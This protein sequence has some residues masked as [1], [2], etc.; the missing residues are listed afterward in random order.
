M[1]KKII[2][3]I[4]PQTHVRATQGDRVFFRIPRDKL[5]PPGLK[6]LLRLERYNEYK[7]SVLAL[8]KQTRFTIPEQGCHITFFIPVSKSWTKAKKEKHHLQLH[9]EKPD[10]DNLG[11]AIFDS[12][13]TED[14]HIADIHLTK[15]WVNQS[16][17]WIEILIGHP[18]IP[19]KDNL[20]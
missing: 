11:K 14:K 17:G 1:Q 13:L 18:S 5:R 9:Q 8:S 6:R 7:I 19:S 15:K 3:D 12:L 10:V 2:L 20:L 16:E 4:T